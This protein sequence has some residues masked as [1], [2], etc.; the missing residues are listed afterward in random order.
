M[1]T[2]TE[3]HTVSLGP[4]RI[5]GMILC[6]TAAAWSFRTN[7]FME[8]K[9]LCLLLGILIAAPRQWKAGMLRA[10]AQRFLIPLL[11]GLLF[12][13]VT[14]FYVAKVPG[15][16]LES[17]VRWQL[18]L[19]AIW[20]ATAAFSVP[21]GRLIL[22]RNLLYSALLVALL[23]LLQYAG[24]VLFLF[25]VFPG[26]SQ[27]AYS[28]FGNQNLLGGYMAMALV[29]L[30]VWHRLDP[31][32]KKSA[33][34]FR[35]AAWLILLAALIISGTRSAWL[36]A[37]VGGAVGVILGRLQYFMK[38]DKEESAEALSVPGKK[39][40]W[41]VAALGTLLLLVWGGVLFGERIKNSFSD[42]DVGGP[43]R[44][45]FWA[46]TARMVSDHPFLGVGLGNYPRWSPSYLGEVL[47]DTRGEIYY[48]NELHTDHAHSE[49]FEW[50]AETGYL[51]AIFWIVF[52]AY[53]LKRRVPG[54]PVLACLGA[55]A[56]VNNF[57]HSPPHTLAFLLLILDPN[58][59][60]EEGK[61]KE[62]AS[63]SRPWVLIA[64]PISI[65]C[66]LM[67]IG[68]PSLLQCAA[69]DRMDAGV[70][71]EEAC[72]TAFSWPWHDPALDESYAAALIGEGDYE[73]ALNHLGYALPKRPTHSVLKLILYCMEA[74][75]DEEMLIPTAWQCVK[76][77]PDDSYAWDLIL[78]AA[79]EEEREDLELC[80]ANFMRTRPWVQGEESP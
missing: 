59:K 65:A 46:G 31:P 18:Y 60:E 73:K 36:A 66:Y 77:W 45:W 30:P 57:T 76:I 37:L 3:K 2:N 53:A 67:I 25:P 33:L 55:F 48:R 22:Y 10:P 40:L 29:L 47:W 79:P 20:L 71:A 8:A 44:L 72:A 17:L 5:W 4:A 12:W 64:T 19:L 51:G 21:G 54:L 50:T 41:G 52:L 78:E 61:E 14:G 28:V 1:S 23:A 69:E 32:Q 24:F 16:V 70:P 43:A 68:V 58:G 56:L 80:R 11:A 27:P 7:T 9:E 39:L 26:Y 62:K 35:V 74:L 15:F 38:W 49:P 42:K 75:E 6:L 13:A 34:L 63:S